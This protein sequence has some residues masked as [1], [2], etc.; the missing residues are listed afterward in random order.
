MNTEA[1]E[2]L[3]TLSTDQRSKL[4]A[5]IERADAI[6]GDGDFDPDPDDAWTDAELMALSLRGAQVLSFSGERLEELFRV[7]FNI[8]G[9][10]EGQLGDWLAVIMPLDAERRVLAAAGGRN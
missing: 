2:Y 3:E 7:E 1:P 6:I 9:V 5:F 10:T 4:L 8:A